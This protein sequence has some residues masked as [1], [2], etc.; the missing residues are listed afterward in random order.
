VL[1]RDFKPDNVLVARD[2][3]ALVT[4]FGL[5]RPTATTEELETL[6]SAPGS[7]WRARDDL[8]SVRA[9][10]GTPP[11]MAPEQLAGGRADER[12]EQFSFCVALFE[13]LH[14]TRPFA[15]ATTELLRTA[16]AS[17]RIVPR[18]A[19]RS[20]PAW[21]DRA[22]LRGL[23]H[24]PAR[25]WPTMQALLAALERGG[26]RRRWAWAAAGALGLAAAIAALRA[27]ADAPELCRGSG[28]RIGQ[29]WGD[30]R[31]ETIHR[32]LLASGRGDRQATA[33]AI[34]REV[35]RYARAW[36]EARQ[37]ACLATHARGEQS[38][39]QLERRM[40]CFDRRLRE[41]EGLLVTLEHADGDALVHAVAAVQRLPPPNECSVGELPL[42]ATPAE[43]GPLAGRLAELRTLTALKQA[44][45]VVP[46]AQQLVRD[47][48]AA[49][50]TP[51]AIEARYLLGKAQ[52]D[53]GERTAADALAET[54]WSAVREGLDELA[55]EVALER[56]GAAV[57][58]GPALAEALEWARHAEA[59]VMRVGGDPKHLG[60]LE[61]LL[62]AVAEARR[63]FAAAREHHE[64]ALELFARAGPAGQGA[65]GS[66]H[67]NYAAALNRAGDVR[68]AREHYERAI[69]RF[70]QH[71][72]GDH[73][74]V[75]RARLELAGLLVWHG[76]EERAR[77]L[78]DRARAGLERSLGPRHPELK[79]AWGVL[80]ALEL[81]HGR[82]G[83]AR[84]ALA[85]A[86]AIANAAYGPADPRTLGSLFDLGAAA[87]ALGDLA[88]ARHFY[89]TALAGETARLGPDHPQL[90]RC[91]TALGHLATAQRRFDAARDHLA[92]ALAVQEAAFGRQNIDVVWIRVH[93]AELA[94]AT[95]ALDQARETYL[96]AAAIAEAIGAT[97][98]VGQILGPLALLERRMRRDADARRHAEAALAVLAPAGQPG[99]EE[100]RRLLDELSPR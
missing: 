91:L 70:E 97:L 78:L 55:A 9:L 58:A 100:L 34:E 14:G 36:A 7:E 4:D 25:R 66:A 6:R 83:A 11:Y 73:P 23:D 1:H 50:A 57:E 81:A 80:G 89:E 28:P 30:A 68:A 51:L 96:D 71:Y 87:E 54:Y 63:D 24:E 93:Q 31:R 65:L 90:V 98:D 74:H 75:H 21:L 38:P 60:K 39:A 42:A 82:H 8:T 48:E 41:L 12:S 26:P 46:L 77:A 84:A 49:A 37:D 76:E 99:V 61:G 79:I 92:R 22:V 3:R 69:E 95:G 62:A 43:D 10:L 19:E 45:K 20:V 17:G 27:P 59:A 33:H 85:R 67:A 47:A 2:G 53:L 35:D 16:M 88:E 5:A 56:V 18:P 13:G 64:R 94:E 32:A 40:A 52:L 29:V 86:Y 72:G 44:A 15:G